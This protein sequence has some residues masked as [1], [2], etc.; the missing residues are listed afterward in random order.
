MR[1][2]WIGAEL[3]RWQVVALL[4]IRRLVLVAQF[5]ERTRGGIVAGPAVAPV[6]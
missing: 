4:F 5:V 3:A 6:V 1:Q 2:G